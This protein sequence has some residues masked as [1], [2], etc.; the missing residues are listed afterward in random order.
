[1]AQDIRVALTLDNKQFNQALKQSEKNVK[2]LTA[3]TAGT[4]TSVKGLAGAFQAFIAIGAV[5]EIVSLT[6]QFTSLNNRLKAVTTSEVQAASALKLVQQVASETRSDLS[7]VAGLF[8]DI[9]IASEELGLS[10]ERVAGIAKVFSQSLK[11]SG[12][13]AGTAA[14]AIRQFGQALAS[15]VLRGDE[16]NSINEANSKFMGELAKALGVTRGE[17]RLMAEQGEIT[18]EIMIMATEKMAENVEE[19]F[20]KTTGTIGDSFTNLKNIIVGTVGEMGESSGGVAAL[21]D[22]IDSLAAAINLLKPVINVISTI[23]GVLGQLVVIAGLYNIAFK[24]IKVAGDIFFNSLKAGKG[25]VVSL[26]DGFKGLAT[27]TTGWFTTAAAG[28]GIVSKFAKTIVFLSKQVLDMG[29]KL[30]RT[31]F[32]LKS[33]KIFFTSSLNPIKSITKETGLFKGMLIGLGKVVIAVT[34][35]LVGILVVY[36]ILKLV[37]K[38]LRGII[39]AFADFLGLDF[40]VFAFIDKHLE[41]LSKK[42]AKA[43]S[44]TW[45]FIKGLVGFKEA[46]EIEEPIDHA[47]VALALFNAQLK[48]VRKELSSG[49]LKNEEAG[50]YAT[51]WENA[52]TRIKKA[53]DAIPILEQGIFNTE[54]FVGPL[55]EKAAQDLEK[56]RKELGATSTELLAAET[57]AKKMKDGWKENFDDIRKDITKGL[58]LSDLKLEIAEFNFDEVDQAINNEIRK[59]QKSAE[60]Q[61]TKLVKLIADPDIPDS[62]K[63]EWVRAL[64]AIPNALAISTAEVKRLVPELFAKKELKKEADEAAAALQKGADAFKSFIEALGGADTPQQLQSLKERLDELSRTGL[65]TGKPLEDAREAFDEAFAN[66]TWDKGVKASLDALELEF[67]EFALAAN[68]TNMIWSNMSSAIDNMVDNGKAGFKDMADSILKDLTKMILKAMLFKHIFAPFGGFLEETFGLDAGTI[69]PGKAKGGS[70]SSN[71]PY[72]VGEEGPELFVPGKS[73]T[74]VPNNALGGGGG[75]VTNNYITNNINALDSKSVQQ[76]FAENR[77]SLLGTVE[78]ARKETAYGV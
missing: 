24:G 69:V 34:R 68:A 50:R 4:T 28:T 38:A 17:L 54:N 11:V 3:T 73:G 77:Q 71:S 60:E 22:A 21:T 32:S 59:L 76:V 23:I 12:A 70:V 7:A 26:K 39:E 15:G 36:D 72:M 1:M 64:E 58:S 51:D 30:G 78:Y 27:A 40:G 56:L 46:I 52:Q 20:G 55:T 18:A 66:L 8:A 35:R 29:E 10:Q 74:I 5:R 41:N 13:D 37:A 63:E 25:K 53:T 61:T 57:A 62:M 43:R 31:I 14:G 33:W 47:T 44:E 6:D 9:T 65:L 67:G 19:A 42:M 49:F 75:P 2:G 48:N 16:F 45:Q